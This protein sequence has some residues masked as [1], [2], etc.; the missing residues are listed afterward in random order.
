MLG[1]LIGFVCSLHADMEFWQFLLNLIDFDTMQA[2]WSYVNSKACCYV[3]CMCRAKKN[4]Q[5]SEL[6]TWFQS[7]KSKKKHWWNIYT[8]NVLMMT[9]GILIEGDDE[10]S[11][12]FIWSQVVVRLRSFLVVALTYRCVIFRLAHPLGLWVAIPLSIRQI[13]LLWYMQWWSVF[14]FCFFKS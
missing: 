8:Y 7:T 14:L 3:L 11:S 5:K 1:F 6:G 12:A 13:I 10:E 4:P 2:E 9:C